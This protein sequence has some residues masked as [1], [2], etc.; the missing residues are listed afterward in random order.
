MQYLLT[1]IAAIEDGCS[2][3]CHAKDGGK[4]STIRRAHHSLI[5]AMKRRF[6]FNFEARLGYRAGLPLQM[7]IIT[8]CTSV[9]ICYYPLTKGKFTTAATPA[10]AK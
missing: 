2:G 9:V 1:E 6:A 8:H 4:D 10:A 3:P 5:I 7:K